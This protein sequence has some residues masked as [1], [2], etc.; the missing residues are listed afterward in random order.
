MILMDDGGLWGCGDGGHGKLGLGSVANELVPA[1]V[2]AREAFGRCKVLTVACGDAHTLAC[3]DDGGLWSWGSGYGGKL[4][5]ADE[6]DRL[7]PERVAA[8]CLNGVKVVAVA[9]ANVHSAAVTED[10]H[11]LTWGVGEIFFP[12]SQELAGL[13]HE[14][15]ERRLVPSVVDSLLEQGTRVGRFLPLSRD[16]SMAVAM[17]THARLGTGHSM[18]SEQCKYLQMPA[19]LVQMVVEACRGWPEGVPA[20]A[21]G[22]ARLM[23]GGRM[24]GQSDEVRQH[25]GIV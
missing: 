15:L 19:E 14:D 13:G 5:H 23:G 12:G 17:G 18:A 22:L 4:G 11:V 8:G 21:S 9:C 1:R 25:D 3:T 10:G 2:G 20:E 6:L 16:H 7:S 24:T